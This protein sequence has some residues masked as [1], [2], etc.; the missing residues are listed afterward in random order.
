MERAGVSE[1]SEGTSE[2]REMSER[3][4]RGEGGGE[5]E[6]SERSEGREREERE[7]SEG[8]GEESCA[9]G[10]SPHGSHSHRRRPGT[11]YDSLMRRW[12][13]PAQTADDRYRGAAVFCGA[14]A[15][16]GWS[17]TTILRA[18]GGSSTGGGQVQPL[19]LRRRIHY[20][21][22]LIAEANLVG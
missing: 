15:S 20:R 12:R 2:R 21:L 18:L 8:R 13:A 5:R 4:E 16:G 22:G 19:R 1:R 7:R 3:E 10:R 14:M 11:T 9:S 6:A 17:F